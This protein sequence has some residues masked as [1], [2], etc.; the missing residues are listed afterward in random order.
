MMQPWIG[1]WDHEWGGES[2]FAVKDDDLGEILAQVLVAVLKRRYGWNVWLDK[3][4][5]ASPAAGLDVVVSGSIAEFSV[6]AWPGWG[7]TNV[8]AKSALALT[9]TNAHDRTAINRMV[10]QEETR[11][12]Y[13]SQAR[14]AEHHLRALLGR[15]LDQSL[16]DLRVDQ[17]LLREP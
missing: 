9:F 11:P 1:T 7:L 4:G 5:I 6:H 12:V 16:K 8:H 14:D 10:E 15:G 17:R 3:P 13:S 2:R